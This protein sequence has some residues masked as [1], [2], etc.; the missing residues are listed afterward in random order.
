MGKSK[1]IAWLT[2]K[3]GPDAWRIALLAVVAGALQALLVVIINDAIAHIGKGNLNFRHFLM[4]VVCM[5]GYLYAFRQSVNLTMRVAGEIVYDTQE[6]L[7]GKLARIDYQAFEKADKNLMYKHLVEST[8]ILFESARGLVNALS[9]AAMVLGSSIY[10]GFLSPMAL[11][12]VAVLV[13]LGVGVYLATEK[14]MTAHLAVSK[15]HER[16]FLAYFKE[17]IAG[18]AEAKMSS[19]VAADLMQNHLWRAS[20]QARESRLVSERFITSNMLSVQSFYFC[21][22]GGIVFVLPQVSQGGVG[23]V[24][25]IAAAALFIMGPVSSVIMAAPLLAKSD[26]AVGAIQDLETML[27]KADDAKDT[28]PHSPLAVRRS[29]ASLRLEGATFQYQDGRQGQAFKLGPLDLD[30]EANQIVFLVGGN[31][32]G[33]STLMKLLAGLYYPQSGRLCLDDAPLTGGDYAHYRDLICLILSGFHIFDRLYGAGAV[34]AKRLEE[35]LGL[36]RLSG[37]TRFEDNAFTTL[38]LSSGQRRR[39]ALALAMLEDK[40]I[41]L[42]DE[43]AADLDPGFRHYFYTQLLPMMKAQGKTVI[44]VSHD[45]RYFHVADRVVKLD[46]GQVAQGGDQ[47][48]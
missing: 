12:A 27:D 4:F 26:Y 6:R 23:L 5:G 48:S 30:I 3:A 25:K 7:V 39:L 1:Y 17:L 13:S 8:D 42:F 24:G 19:R 32:T 9:G 31:G 45:D 47:A 38:D 18:F 34:D 14:K 35:L 20:G 21:L 40:P 33:K 46:Y 37:V 28:D 41:M 22:I 10:I 44:A 36:M 29:F 16:R 15:E 11:V 2:A 43:V